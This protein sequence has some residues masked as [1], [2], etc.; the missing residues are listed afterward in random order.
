MDVGHPAQQLVDGGCSQAGIPIPNG[1]CHLQP[2]LGAGPVAVGLGALVLPQQRNRDLAAAEHQQPLVQV[3]AGPLA[4]RLDDLNTGVIRNSCHRVLN[5]GLQ[6][7]Q[8]RL[9]L[10][11]RCAA[12][13]FAHQPRRAIFLGEGHPELEPTPLEDRG[14]EAHGQIGMAIRVG[15][16]GLLPGQQELARLQRFTQHRLLTAAKPQL[17]VLVKKEPLG[18]LANHLQRHR[19]PV[20]RAPHQL[21]RLPAKKHRLGDLIQQRVHVVGGQHVASQARH[22]GA[23]LATHHAP[24]QRLDSGLAA[25]NAAAHVGIAAQIAVHADVFALALQDRVRVGQQKAKT[26]H[27][28]AAVAGGDLLGQG[29]SRPG[30]CEG[31]ELGGGNVDTAGHS[32]Q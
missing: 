6:L 31:N 20:E 11:T 4:T 28:H 14:P 7:V 30:L 15:I 18:R 32:G 2:G 8:Q 23:G 21:Q 22:A 17:C 29:F 27:I 26:G 1:L 25:A 13:L 12:W 10:G 9:N 19:C 24:L 3:S 5:H 16:T